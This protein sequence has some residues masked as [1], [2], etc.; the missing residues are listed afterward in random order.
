TPARSAT[1]LSVTGT[2]APSPVVDRLPVDRDV[3]GLGVLEQP[4]V[5]TLAPDPGL[6]DPTERR[7]GVRDDAAV[8]PDHP[9]LERRAHAPRAHHARPPP[10]RARRPSRR[11]R[12]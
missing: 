8:D 11:P 5:A 6:L 12:R 4:L 10:G 9:R 7:C 2:R 3:L 1:S